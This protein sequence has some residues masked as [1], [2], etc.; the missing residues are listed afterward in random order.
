MENAPEQGKK[1][2]LE[3]LSRED[4]LKKCKSLLVIAQKA[5]TA[6]DTYQ[7]EI[8]VLKAQLKKSADYENEA[9]RE[10]IENLTQQ[11]LSLVTTIE[12]L[13][14]KNQF[15][16]KN[17][18]Q[19]QEKIDRCSQVENENVSFKRQNVRLTEENE[20]L[21][22]DLET[23]EKQ[24]SEL[25]KLGLEQQTQLLE[26]E[27]SK[28]Q[29]K[30]V[31]EHETKIKELQSMLS[32]S[33]EE[34]KKLHSENTMSLQKIEDLKINL[35]EKDKNILTISQELNSK[36]DIVESLTEEL[37]LLRTFKSENIS[38]IENY[39]KLKLD[40]S[41]LSMKS[42]DSSIAGEDL[43]E[44][45]NRLKE[46]LKL[47]HSK[48]VKYAGN[49]KI[50]KNDKKEI[51]RLFMVYTDQVK[52]WEKQLNLV[53]SKLQ[54]V[55]RDFKSEKDVLLEENNKLTNEAKDLL[56]LH[57]DSKNVVEKMKNK[58]E[59]IKSKLKEYQEYVTEANKKLEGTSEKSDITKEIESLKN[60]II[61]LE[62]ENKTLLN[63]QESMKLELEDAYKKLKQY[64]EKHQSFERVIS[65][66]EEKIKNM[67][68]SKNTEGQ[69]AEISG[70][71]ILKLVEEN[72][73]LK[74][75]FNKVQ[76]E[77]DTINRI[78]RQSVNEECQT[79]LQ[80]NEQDE[81]FA[82]LKRENGELLREMNEM[83]QALKERGES[84]S[85]LEAHCEE[86]MK[87]LQVYETQANK[88]DDNA[89][90]KDETIKKLTKDI[91]NLQKSSNNGNDNKASE[92]RALK[93]EIE[94]LKEKINSNMDSS[95]AES[96]I[97]STSTISRAD[98]ANR[99]KDL[100]GSWEER[101]GKLRNL[102]VKLK[103]KVKELT[104]VNEKDSREKE[105]LQ[106]KLSQNLKTIQTLQGQIDNLQD[107]LE[108]AKKYEARLNTIAEEISKDKQQLV[109][110]EETI[111]KL[112]QELEQL[113]NEKQS[114]ET[115]KK[116]VS[117]KIQL[118]RKELEANTLLKKD[119]EARI[120]RLNSDLDA[121]E[122]QLKSE[123]EN[124]SK[125]KNLLDQS[126]NECKKNS[127]L[128][129]E[130][131]DYERSTK[132]LAQKIEK[133]DELITKLKSQVESQKTTLSAL[134]EQHKMLEEK[135]QSGETTLTSASS[136][137]NSYR[138]KISELE[139]T[140]QIKEDKIHSTTD[141]LESVRSENEEL[142]TELSKVIAEHQK[143][144][145]SVKS[146]KDHLRSQVLGLQ[147]SLRQTQGTLKLKED[148]LES[149]ISEY[150]GYKVRAQS[151][152]RQ[153]QTRDVGLEEKLNEEVTTLK[154][155]NDLLNSRLK[156]LQDNKTD[157][158]KRNEKI[159]SDKEE[160][161]K[162]FEE[163]SAEVED[164]KNQ[165]AQ[166]SNKH[167]KALNE[168]AETVRSL[169]VHA[170]TLSQCYRQQIS[171]Q[172][173]RHNRE[174]I[175]LQSKLDK[176]PTPNGDPMLPY[177]PTTPREEGEG[178]ESIESLANAGI[179]QPVPLERLLGA[180]TDREVHSLR[181]NLTDQESKVV[182]LTA[183]LADTE[184]D[185]AKHVQMN[186]M[187]KE[188]IRRQQRSVER[189]KHA[190][191]LE[192]LKNVVF[193]FVTLNSGDERTRLIPVL[194]TILKLSPEETQKLSLVAKGDPGLRG[195][196]NYLPTWS[197]PTKPQ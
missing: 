157:L 102:A 117:A 148:E 103:A 189:E 76:Q 183:L 120:S 119:F 145:N 23:L 85:Q 153:N 108:H 149:V 196:S 73:E 75:N 96:D 19:M 125:T 38:I 141:L 21:I 124:H 10:I 71:E 111:S 20:Q 179:Q 161:L 65:D 61:K 110:N 104:T 81:Q 2:N 31:G 47:Y 184:Q 63:A 191:N 30:N 186:K 158:E 33:L 67:E 1:H 43:L 167:Q 95:Y 109:T 142:S 180:D 6:K 100:E 176:A 173:S 46:K 87:K 69:L 32:I 72:K 98:E 160:V 39:D 192:Y 147:Q 130:M 118:L 137:I 175:E 139:N 37:N 188:E 174:I 16:E 12:E 70:E 82:N 126:S 146:E 131:Q 57:E 127:V 172:E 159:L 155:Q 45:N 18:E 140:V 116:Q 24:I 86:V 92:I 156:K 27:K 25:N 193:K 48:L 106:K 105:E 133:K 22:S 166:L 17:V 52:D 168:H 99:L 171:E 74:E 91:E 9:T 50:L 190:E 79:K 35:G 170:E 185:L 28:S 94:Q 178:S 89:S 177:P 150:E 66:Y 56:K 15:L 144:I 59:A 162:K 112:K 41:E 49:M 62:T 44:I 113:K 78:R 13:K 55:E 88:N 123:M 90:Q 53:V 3:D 134:R 128:N 154:S 169:K 93:N 164:L 11:K 181:K 152:L 64:K 54:Q 51:L 151:V 195:W 84:I 34:V 26:L 197:S 143:A 97:M 107:E 5:K 77:L 129:L 187:L 80:N 101:Y 135:L 182:Y 68:H 163:S 165:F 8:N 40:Y 60:T 14:H 136:E 194:N 132:E 138:K 36:C 42:K 7:E 114:T 4:L 122:Q 29:S 121:K 115:W 58:K 83:N